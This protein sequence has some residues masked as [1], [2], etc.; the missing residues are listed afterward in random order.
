MIQIENNT[1]I[2]QEYNNINFTKKIFFNG[3]NLDQIVVETKAI[4]KKGIIHKEQFIAISSTISDQIIQSIFMNPQYY[5]DIKSIELL[6][7][8]P[9][10]VNL[11][12]Y[13]EFKKNGLNTT[14]INGQRE[15]KQFM[16]YNEL[17]HQ[18]LQ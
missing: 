2:I 16:P 6:T 4:M 18:R 17:F 13:L 5:N 11:T 12:L 10:K 14:V 9:L 15:E 3:E 7:S 8:K 1:F